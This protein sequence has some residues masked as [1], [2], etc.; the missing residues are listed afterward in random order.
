M[1]EHNVSIAV[2][3]YNPNIF[4]LYL[5]LESIIMQK[6]IQ[7]EIIISD[8]GSN[9]FPSEMIKEYFT[10]RGFSNYKIITHIENKGTVHNCYDALRHCNYKYTKLFS[11]GDL[12][13]YPQ[14]LYDWVRYMENESYVVSFGRPIAYSMV[15]NRELVTCQVL[16]HPQTNKSKCL[17]RNCLLGKDSI[18]GAS[19]MVE[20]KLMIEY[21]ERIINRVIYCEDTVYRLMLLDEM[22]VGIYNKDSIFY[23]YGLGISTSKSSSWL[24]MLAKD[25]FVFDNILCEYANPKRVFDRRLVFSIK[26]RRKGRLGKIIAY[27]FVPQLTI[28][29]LK[30]R[31]F[32]NKTNVQFN[33]DFWNTL[34]NNVM[35]DFHFIDICD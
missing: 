9:S 25:Y 31:F 5:T 7:Y 16:N 29:R 19:V 13:T 21:L 4:K 30:T 26:S 6:K 11:P 8:D 24:K 34:Y 17:K 12:L 1:E 32:P 35:N 22:S 15:K 10:S 18:L 20:T 23:E 27:L 28:M 2:L 3:T 14:A 33:V